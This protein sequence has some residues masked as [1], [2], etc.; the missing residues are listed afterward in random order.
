MSLQILEKS[1]FVLN[2]LAYTRLHSYRNYRRN[3]RHYDGYYS[4][5]K[6]RYKKYRKRSKRS[7]ERN[8]SRDRRSRSEQSRSGNRHVSGNEVSDLENVSLFGEI[9]RNKKSQEYIEKD[10]QL[11]QK[12]IQKL[13]NSNAEEINKDDSCKSPRASPIKK[14]P[15]DKQKKIPTNTNDENYAERRENKKEVFTHNTSEKRK[16]SGIKKC[17]VLELPMPP[18]SSPIKKRQHS[19]SVVKKLDFSMPPPSL[20]ERNSLRNPALI[21]NPNFDLK[22]EH[23][24]NCD[25]TVE[26]LKIT[27]KEMQSKHYKDVLNHLNKYNVLTPKS[28]SSLEVVAGK[29][30]TVINKGSPKMHLQGLP[31]SRFKIL[32]Q[33]GEGTYGKVFKAA[34]VQTREVVAMKM[35]RMENEREGFPL[36]CTREIT[37]LQKLNHENIIAIYDVI[38]TTKPMG[39]YLIFEYMNHD[40][41]GLIECET[42]TFN[43]PTIFQIMKQILLGIEYCH[44]LKIIHRDIKTANIL[45]NSRGTV[46]LADFGLARSWTEGR[47]YTSKVVSLW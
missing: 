32:E 7:R 11:L 19:Q 35:I 34:D 31:L 2:S 22:S 6:S 25:S 15:S 8:R 39:T 23:F 10:E 1:F 9:L 13:N 45:I 12:F 16:F 18:V 43:E 27:T 5:D 28:N 30:P 42:M 37:S 14:S 47:P 36:T 17:S 21:H 24:P 38:S 4:R 41:H 33:V 46:K 40:L 3:R 26:K 29:R 20:S 44:R